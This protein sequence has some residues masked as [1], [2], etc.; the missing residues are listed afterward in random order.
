M[1]EAGGIDAD[2]N[3]CAGFP[4]DYY[5]VTCSVSSSFFLHFHSISALIF[6]TLALVNALRP[7]DVS[8]L[9]ET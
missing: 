2:M 3:V 7:S 5:I 8:T 6:D 1:E 4:E 9:M